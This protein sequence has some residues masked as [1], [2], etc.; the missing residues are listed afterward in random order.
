MKV[1]GIDGIPPEQ[2]V[3]EIRR[4]AKFVIYEYCISVFIVTV[5]KDSEVFYIRPGQSRVSGGTGFTAMSLLTGWFG[6]P[7]GPIYT[8]TS[9]MTNLRGGRDVTMQVAAMLFPGYMAMNIP[10][11]G[12]TEAIRKTSP[13]TRRR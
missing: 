8:I 2:I 10:P 9:V 5:R 4:G 7:H 3:D 13:P 11:E 6:F 12:W 1:N